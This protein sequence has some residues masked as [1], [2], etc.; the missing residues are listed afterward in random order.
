MKPTLHYYNTPEGIVA[1]STTRH[2]GCSVGNHGEMNI[3]L[4]CG[5]EVENVKANRKLLAEELNIAEDRLVLPHQV[6]GVE[7]RFIADE[8]MALPDS[9]K[10]AVVEGV[11]ALMTNCT[12]I[13]IGVSTADCIPV[14]LIDKAHRAVSAIHAGWRGT[15]N[16]IV[17]KTLMEM[18]SCF[19]TVPRDVMAI[20]GPGISLKNFEVGQ[21]VY[22][23]FAQA[24]NDM[25]LISKMYDK[26]HIDLPRCN[27]IQLEQAGVCP[28]NIMMSDIC[29]FDAVDDY[30][31]ARKLGVDSGRIFT[32]VILK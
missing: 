9:V 22:D 30:F 15:L 31:S 24:G 17:H 16:R 8:F 27:R 3:N 20:I 7:S 26:W 5:D 19:Q 6:H 4:Y 13:C 11:D 21:E 23:A 28:D 12:G 14:I 32:G 1:F 29:T 25:D 2:G 18:Q 10:G